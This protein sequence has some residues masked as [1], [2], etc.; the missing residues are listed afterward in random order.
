MAAYLCNAV[1]GLGTRDEGLRV[2]V[3]LL[4]EHEQ[5]LHDVMQHGRSALHL[6]QVALGGAAL[7]EGE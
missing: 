2:R 1:D 6:H 5:Q 3:G 4:H 7:H